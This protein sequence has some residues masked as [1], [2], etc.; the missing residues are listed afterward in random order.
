MDEAISAWAKISELEPDNIFARIELADLFREQK[1]YE[2]AIEQYRA[3][4][5]I[6]QDVP[7][8]ICLSR[9]EIGKIQEE[10]G[11]YAGA[12]QNYDAAL[13]LTG[14][15]NWLRKDL[16]HRVIGLYAADGDWDG[17][18]AYYQGK[19]DATPN[20]PELIGLLAS[21]YI[22]NQRLDDGIASYQK[23]LELAPTDA[24]LRLNLIAAFRT[25][26]IYEDAAAE[27]ELLSEEQPDDFGI[28]RELGD[29]YLQ[30]EDETRAKGAYQRMID[31]D[32]ENAGT[33]LILAEIYAGHEWLD[34]AVAAYEKA[35]L[36]L[37]R[38][39]LITSSILANSTSVKGLVRRLWKRGIEWLPETEQS[40]KTMTG[41]RSRSML[42]TFKPKQL[43]RVARR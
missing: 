28:Y 33:H 13:A 31:R 37:R 21:A 32:P 40:R 34:D 9:R 6:K 39:I 8:R 12:I 29:L 26:E 3:L 41:L 5:E 42:R 22:E 15:G 24:G 18:I 16:Q 27:Y 4:I 35:I 14:Q 36:L 11:D 2:Q 38:T 19:L 30:L 17:L 1:L 43:V 20:D 23:G 10:K 7:Y 25:A